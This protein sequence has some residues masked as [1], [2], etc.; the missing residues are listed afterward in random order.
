MNSTLLV[1]ISTLELCL[2]INETT[3]T[4]IEI[5]EHGILDVQGDGPDE[6][7]FEES[8]LETAQ[9]ALRLRR[10]LEINWPGIA[11]ALELLE[12]KQRVITENLQL[13]QQLSRFLV[14]D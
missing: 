7:L 4:V 9:R 3:E 2:H 1:H 10:D 6:W 8:A 11:L 12:E 13:R 14:D 5:V